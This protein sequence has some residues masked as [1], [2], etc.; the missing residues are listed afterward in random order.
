MSTATHAGPDAKKGRSSVLAILL[1]MAMFVL[2]IDTSLMN[3]SI[4]AIVNDLNTTVSSVQAAIA[5]EALV[6]AAFI[7]TCSKIGDLIGRKRAYVLG[8]LGYAV[9]ALAMTLTNSVTLI[10]IFWAIIGGLGAALLLPAMQSLIQGNFEGDAKK[11]AYALV[12]A[13]TGIAAAIGPLLGGFITTYSSWRVG[14]LL[15]AIIIAIV[16]LNIRMVKDVPYT[17]PRQ[18]DLVGAALSAIGMGGIV[19]G[20]LAWQEG[21]ESVLLLMFIGAAAMLL[22][23]LWLARRKKQ[24]KSMLLDPALFSLKHFRAG[25][26]SQMLQNI[27][28]GGMMIV[29]PIY[30]QM[31]YEYT[32]LQTGI[33]I[34]PL[35]LSIFATSILAGRL[36]AKRRSSRI[37]QFGFLV[38]VVGVGLLIPLIPRADSGLTFLIPLAVTGVGLGLLVSQLNNYTLSPIGEERVSEAAGVNSASGSFGLSFGLALAGALML[39][40]LAFNFNTLA[41]QSAVLAPEQKQQVAQ[42]LEE[43]AQIM[44]DTQLTE[45]IASQPAEV[46]NEIIR[47]NNEARHVALQVALLVPLLAGL[48]G[49]L[50]SFRMVRLPDLEPSSAAEGL[51]MG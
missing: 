1:A 28:L 18:I 6:S 12:G 48:S 37:I 15:E 14:F 30:F 46:Q 24:S 43:D 5:L 13:A 42:A 16:L 39:A 2:V 19:L 32:A 31:V 29:L 27:A 25:I 51:S 45:Q 35:S 4:S 47:I 10:I 44:S 11:R 34:A 26:S 21:G 40:V 17:G 3:V 8:L 7:L 22:L 36:A 41:Q 9:G 38:L 49:L 33:S 23:A 50:V 20:I